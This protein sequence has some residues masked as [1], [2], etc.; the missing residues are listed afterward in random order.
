MKGGCKRQIGFTCAIGLL[1]EIIRIV[2]IAG[3]VVVVICFAR[4]TIHSA[5]LPDENQAQ[6]ES[7][8]GKWSVNHQ[9]YN[10]G[11]PTTIKKL[12]ESLKTAK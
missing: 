1:L 12:K 11:E 10:A 2:V 9:C 6:C 8:G 7:L 4:D 3:L 5:T